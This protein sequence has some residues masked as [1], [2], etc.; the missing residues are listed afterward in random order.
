MSGP[1]ERLRTIRKHLE[2][3]ASGSRT[4]SRAEEKPTIPIKRFVFPENFILIQLCIKSRHELLKWNG[5]GYKDSGF[6]V[7]PSTY[8]FTFTGDRYEIGNKNLPNFRSWTE[9]TLAI[10]LT[11]RIPPQPEISTKDFPLQ[12]LNKEFMERLENFEPPILHSSDAQDRLFR[13]HGHTLHEIITLRNGVFKRIPDIVVWPK[14]TEEVEIIVKLAQENNVV[15]IPFGGGTSVSGALECPTGE[16]R[17]I[18]SLDLSQ[19][20]KCL[21]INHQNLTARFEAGIIGQ[22]LESHL[23]KFGLCVGHVP[24]SFEFSTLGGWVA[25]KASGMK[26]NVYGNIEDIVIHVQMVTTRGILE[27]GCEVPRI[28]AGPDIHYFILGS[29]GTLGVITEVTLK[30]RPL[31]KVKKYNSL[32]FP[33]FESGVN[34]MKEV[35]KRRLKPSSIRLMDNE[36]FIFGQALKP[37]ADSFLSSITDCFKKLFLTQIKGLDL[38]KICVATLLF[39]GDADDV[40]QL[41]E[42]VLELAKSF[43]G[44]CA[45]EENGKRGYM[46]TFVIA[47]IRVM[48]ITI[49]VL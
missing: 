21:F 6:Q 34:L 14:I 2:Q 9:K 37:E 19:M 12:I 26:K 44:L 28:A 3:G 17:M 16:Q 8:M 47:Y 13:S 31:P 46:L 7:D 42:Q 18:I 20:N 33:S 41:E 38:S 15:I 29:E 22:D 36:Q 40:A 39:E 25:T 11:Q 30:V 24:D 35:A 45:G 32:V 23:S 5:W 4:T 48:V 10:D 27:R 49:V 43:N 1:R